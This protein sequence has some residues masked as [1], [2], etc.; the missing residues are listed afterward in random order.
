MKVLAWNGPKQ[1][2]LEERSIPE[3]N[4]NEVLIKVDVAGIC[5]SEI[6]GFLGHNSLRVPPLIMGHEFCG[7][8]EKTGETAEHVPKGA[9]VVVNPLIHC[10]R[11]EKC[12]KGL[13]NL[14]DHRQIVGIHRSGAFADYVVVPESAVVEVPASLDSYTASLSEPLACCF[15]AVRRAL[16]KHPLANV[17]IYGAGTIGVLSALTAEI[18]G[19]NRIIMADIN[20]ERLATMKKAGINHTLNP[21]KTDVK[22]ALPKI[23]GEKGIDVIID[24]AGF[25]PTRSQAAEVINSGGVIMNIGLGINETPLPINDFIRNEVTVLGS[26]CYSRQDFYDAVQLLEE[27]KVNPAGWSEVRSLEDGQQAFMDLIEGRV[28]NSKIFLQINK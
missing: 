14:C 22:E 4:E 25:L 28:K 8:V 17:F 16:D 3:P 24:A 18:L 12:R 19:A 9:K 15:R 5:G 23:A 26:F 7:Y 20:E 2:N 1:M 27:G 6:E 11:C 21:E 13:E 10:G